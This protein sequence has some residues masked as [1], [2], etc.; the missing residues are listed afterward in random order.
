MHRDRVRRKCVCDDQV[1]GG[2]RRVAQPEPAIAEDECGYHG[3]F[4]P[5]RKQRRVLRHPGNG[6]ID[7][8]DR[9]VAARLGVAQ[10]HAGA[11][12]EY[13][14]VRAARD[15][16]VEDVGHRRVGPVVAQGLAALLGSQGLQAVERGA[17]VERARMQVGQVAD[18]VVP[19]ECP[20]TQQRHPRILLP[21]SQDRQEGRGGAQREHARAMPCNHR[22]DQGR[23][24]EEVCE[25]RGGGRGPGE[26][27]RR[28]P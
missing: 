15:P 25:P 19:V 13:G 24:H 7:L 12:A 3:R 28:E 26:A 14:D 5:M 2:I 11:Q 10:D 9:P 20:A 4:N 27:D 21:T 6:R 17:V 1:V 22:Q 18:G 16:R 8:V 23:Q